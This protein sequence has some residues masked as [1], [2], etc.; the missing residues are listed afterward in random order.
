MPHRAVHDHLLAAAEPLFPDL[1]AAIRHQGAL[2]LPRRDDLAFPD[3]LC[4]AIAGQQISV[5]AAAAIWGRVEASAGDADLLDHF[6]PGNTESLRACGLSGAKTRTIITIAE[7]HRTVGLD[8]DVLRAL[9]IGQRSARLTEIWG[10]GQWTADMM[11]IF[12][13]GEGDVWPD[14]D[15]AARKTLERLTSRRRKTVRTAAMFKP[16]RSW[17]AYYMWAHVDAP[18][19]GATA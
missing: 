7:T 5:K 8:T 2:K 12:Y 1:Y 6:C 11:N 13:F 14:G 9:P 4:R 19:D 17:L 15:V 16:Y 18:P 3:Y 10:V